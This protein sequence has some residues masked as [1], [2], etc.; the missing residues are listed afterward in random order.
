[1]AVKAVAIK[2]SAAERYVPVGTTRPKRVP[3]TVITEII[4]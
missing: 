3:T 1:M 4:I 2:K